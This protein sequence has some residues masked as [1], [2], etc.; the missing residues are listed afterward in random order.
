VVVKIYTGD[1]LSVLPQLEP[2][3]HRS[4]VTSVPYWR[5]RRYGDDP[6]EIGQEAT[7]QFWVTALVRAFRLVRP[8]LTEDGSLWLN[9]GDKFAAGGMGGGGMA[10]ARKA[11]RGTMGDVGWRKP[12]PGYKPKDLTL[13]PFMLAE[14][15]RQDGWY[16]RQTIVWEKSVA[17]E[18]PRLDRPSVSHEYLFLFSVSEQSAVRDPGEPWFHSTVWRIPHDADPSHVA[19]MPVE[20]ARRCVVA[21]TRPGD[22]VLDPFGGSGTTA[23]AADRNGRHATIVELYPSSVELARSKATA[24]AGPLFADIEVAG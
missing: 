16:L 22:R 7:P 19:K 4:C 3:S 23:I 14:A 10:A 6:A 8:A 17:V 15:L 18:P 9:V 11:W 20:L 1:A 12:P 24:D 2:G 13:T 5:Q 21:S